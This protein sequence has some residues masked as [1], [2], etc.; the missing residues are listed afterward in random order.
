[1]KKTRFSEE[2]MVKILRESSGCR[3]AS[4]E[5][6]ARVMRTRDLRVG[7]LAAIGTLALCL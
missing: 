2:Q 3:E 7:H 6:V 1:M 5:V 4:A